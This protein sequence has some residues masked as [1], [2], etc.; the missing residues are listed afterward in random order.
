MSLL[1]FKYL[2]LLKPRC[3][4]DLGQGWGE[5]DFVVE[6]FEV[7]GEEMEGLSWSLRDI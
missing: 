4:D 3:F 2:K 1:L 6:G 7:C 5:R